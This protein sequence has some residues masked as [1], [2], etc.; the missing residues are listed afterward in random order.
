[1]AQYDRRLRRM[2]DR[3]VARFVDDGGSW[4][5]YTPKGGLKVCLDFF[6]QVAGA[7]PQA[8]RVRRGPVASPLFTRKIM[9][10]RTPADPTTSGNDTPRP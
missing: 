7:I 4:W 3:R 8:W 10:I 9:S 2:I 6:V 1:M 5:S